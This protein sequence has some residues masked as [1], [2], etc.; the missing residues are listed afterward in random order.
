MINDKADQVMTRLFQSLPSRC[1]IGLETSMKGTKL[2]FEC[3]HL[4]YGK[5]HKINPNC[6]RSYIDSP[7][8]IKYN[9]TGKN[10]LPIRK[11]LL[12]KN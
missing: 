8:W 7:D 4:L 5:Y 11:S 3:V 1:Q 12:E 2:V 10:K 6:V 9:N